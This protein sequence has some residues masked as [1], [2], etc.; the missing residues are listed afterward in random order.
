MVTNLK[1]SNYDKA[2]K[3]KP[4]TTQFLTVLKK[5]LLVRAT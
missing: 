4:D 5:S 1:N 3:L 2:Q